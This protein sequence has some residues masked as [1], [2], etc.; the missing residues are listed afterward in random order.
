M[1]QKTLAVLV[2]LALIAIEGDTRLLFDGLGSHQ[3][4]IPMTFNTSSDSGSSL[5]LH[6]AMVSIRFL[7]ATGSRAMATQ[8]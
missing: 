4:S 7:S 1:D 2:R 5:R 8:I 6:L 3:Y